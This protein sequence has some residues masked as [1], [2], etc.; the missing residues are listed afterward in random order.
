MPSL[1]DKLFKSKPPAAAIVPAT[2]APFDEIYARATQAMAT[3]DFARALQL[4]D[5]AIV[6]NP[7]H[8]EAHYKRG[9]AL[10]MLGQPDAAVASY[11]RAIE[12]NTEYAYAY[13]NRGSVQH[14]LGLLDAAASSFDKAIA[15]AP[16]DAVAHYNRALL[17][18][19][20][21]R[22]EEALAGYDAAISV[23]PDYT[24]AHYNRSLVALYLGEF[25]TG[26][27]GFEWRWDHAQQLNIGA[28]R[29][30]EQPLW[31]GEAPLA[32][33]RLLIYSE[34][35]LGDT[36]QFSRYAALCAAQGATVILEVQKPLL[37]ALTDLP[38]VTQL[39]AKGTTLP[40]FDYQ[41]PIMSLPLAFK[42]TLDTI[43]AP[44]N[45]LQADATRVVEWRALLGERKRPR[46]G[47]VWS[48]NS[49][50][51]I[52]RHRS[53]ALAEWIPHLPP[54]FDYFC[55]QRDI[56]DADSA[57]LESS[58]LFSFDDDLMD[59]KSTAALCECMDL[60]I[61]VDTSLLHLSGALGKRSWLLLPFAPDWRWLRDRE[62]T[63]WYP[64]VKLY[65]Q[66]AA[67]DWSGVFARVAADLRREL[68]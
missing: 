36:L 17:M 50:N 35:G 37:A 45:Y 41:I 49:N 44:A 63:P 10:R 27:A 61:S 6:L 25:A 12:L 31:L 9:N 2:E 64:S 53:V 15:L 42:T 4:H 19:D 20:F 60:V 55:L 22:W 11:D 62:D 18:Q 34:Q 3:K 32:G 5:Q 58:D 59:F 47:I 26:W 39:L 8:A 51:P 28:V 38:G 29:N 66:T 48:G 16:T 43:P 52:D 40:P 54:E 46:V 23:N 57:A 65:R 67:G 33:K 1:F 14:A 56:R 68:K 13:C 7:T 21:F 24:S 30:F